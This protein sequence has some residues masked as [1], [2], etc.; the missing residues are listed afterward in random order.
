MKNTVHSSVYALKDTRHFGRQMSHLCVQTELET[1]SS[2]LYYYVQKQL[3][4]LL[5]MNK[6][7]VFLWLF[8]YRVYSDIFIYFH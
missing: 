8:K 4:S 2:N 5:S 3:L 1:V 6:C 7:I